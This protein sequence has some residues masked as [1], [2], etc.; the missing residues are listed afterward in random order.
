M[1]K[2]SPRIFEV[3]SKVQIDS[4]GNQSIDISELAR[5]PLVKK[6]LTK[7]REGFVAEQKYREATRDASPSEAEVAA[8]VTE[9]LSHE[10]ESQELESRKQEAKNRFMENEAS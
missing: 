1:P 6:E 4:E 9:E 3:P 10:I 8:S 5:D 2:K 7:L